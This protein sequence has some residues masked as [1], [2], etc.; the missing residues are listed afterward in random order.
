MA[1]I[2]EGITSDWLNNPATLIYSVTEISSAKLEAWS[3]H[4][5]GEAEAWGQRYSM[6]PLRMLYDLSTSGVSMPFL[7]LTKYLIYN[8]GLTEHG[9]HAI[10]QLLKQYPDLSIRYALLI[11]KNASGAITMKRGEQ[12]GELPRC[13]YHVYLQ[14]D[15]AIEW[16]QR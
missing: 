7:L 14:Y 2:V 5:V 3:E 1:F 4:V 12:T 8:V 6:E 15:S 16:L 9:T 11:S 13:E 10:E